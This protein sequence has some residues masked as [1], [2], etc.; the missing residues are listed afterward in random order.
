MTTF[1]MNQNE[2][3]IFDAR[4]DVS[5]LRSKTGVIWK[6]AKSNYKQRFP[7]FFD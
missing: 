3:T 7:Y 6:C 1:F 5:F 4:N 2:T